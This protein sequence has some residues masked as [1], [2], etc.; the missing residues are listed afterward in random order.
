MLFLIQLIVGLI[1]VVIWGLILFAVNPIL[2]VLWWG[3]CIGYVIYKI[4]KKNN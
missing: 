1:A 3:W 2:G 4:K